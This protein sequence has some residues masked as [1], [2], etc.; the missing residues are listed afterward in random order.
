MRWAT[1]GSN[2]V[3]DLLARNLHCSGRSYCGCSD[4]LYGYVDCLG[5]TFDLVTMTLHDNVKLL[6]KTIHGQLSGTERLPRVGFTNSIG[7][8]AV[9][10]TASSRGLNRSEIRMMVD[11]GGNGNAAIMQQ[12][13]LMIFEGVD[14]YYAAN[15]HGLR[16][17]ATTFN[18]QDIRPDVLHLGRLDPAKFLDTLT[19]FDVYAIVVSDAVGHVSA[20]AQ[21]Q[22]AG[23]AVL[24]VGSGV[25][26]SQL[27]EEGVTGF[28]T[29]TPPDVQRALETIG[30]ST[31]TRVR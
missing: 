3:N 7:A 17:K 18:C 31:S 15:P 16:V 19:N 28:V 6:E 20:V 29:E 14:M 2:L 22:M 12:S 24:A 9:W 8:E 26:N 27:F 23:I 13:S 11:C 30:G 25:L 21:V 1:A 5:G 4:P 10:A